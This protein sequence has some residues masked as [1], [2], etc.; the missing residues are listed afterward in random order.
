M[1]VRETAG[2]RGAPQP[3]IQM[4]SMIPA[5]AQVRFQ[6]KLTSA[7]PAPEM[8]S[9]RKA[10]PRK[11]K[12]KPARSKERE[13]CWIARGPLIIQTRARIA[14]T[15]VNVPAIRLVAS[16]SPESRPISINLFSSERLAH[17]R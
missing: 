12:L 6:R 16:D 7:L 5:N 4:P 3:G 13:Y 15:P 10:R 9:V 11:P 14:E 1:V 8:V 2:C 17:Q